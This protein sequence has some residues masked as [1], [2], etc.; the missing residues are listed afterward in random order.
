MLE[1]YKET[2]N[3]LLANEGGSDLKIVE[4][5]AKGIYV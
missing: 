4:Q 2:L 5:A 3:D 1:I